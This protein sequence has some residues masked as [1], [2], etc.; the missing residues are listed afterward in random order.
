MKEIPADAKA[1]KKTDTFDQNSIPKAL[2][3]E[4]S[5]K[6]EVWGKIVILEGE[7]LYK[8]PSANEEYRLTPAKF[9]VVEPEVKHL[10]APIENVK[11]YVE[12]YK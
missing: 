11:F 2:L 10:V 1:Y 8:I 7:L 3:N 9:G 6:S 4:H 5:T 12:F